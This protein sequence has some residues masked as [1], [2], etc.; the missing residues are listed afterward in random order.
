MFSKYP[1]PFSITIILIIS[2][3]LNQAC[4][5]PASHSYENNHTKTYT[6]KKS[7][8]FALIILH[9]NDIHSHDL[10]F[11][12]N[13][14]LIGGLSKIAY[15][16]SA[17][18]ATHNNVIVVDAGDFFQGTP[19]FQRY[20][21]AVEIEALNEI[22]YDIVELG[23][24][25]FDKGAQYLANQLKAAKFPVLACNL[26]CSALPALEQVV[27]A[28]IIKEI[29]GEKIAFIG[30]IT[31][32]LE[33][34]ALGLEGV[35]VKAPGGDWLQPIKEEVEYYQNQGINKI[36][37]VSH[38]GVELDKDLAAAIPSIDLI[39]GGHSHTT[40]K[41]PIWLQH[42]DGTYTAI[43]QTGCY[44]RALGDIDLKFDQ[45]G[46][47]I[48]PKT[49]YRLISINSNL[50]DDP[51]L[52]AYL[53]EKEKPLLALANNIIGTA[54]GTFWNHFANMP[55]DSAIGNL[56][57]DAMAEATAN[58]A[59][60]ITFQNRGGIRAKLEKS[61]I[62]EEKIQEILP[63]DNKIVCATLSG[64]ALLSLL[65]CSLSGPH[66]GAFF[67][68]HGLKI[69]YDP[70]ASPDKRIISILVQNEAGNWLPLEK[71]AS[72]KIAV[73]DYNFKGGDGYDFSKATDVKYTD[74]KLAD[75]LRAYIIKHKHVRPGFSHR[76]M[77]ISK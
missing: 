24:H 42:P 48:K 8:D 1:S 5:L 75:A 7:K 63:F 69:T 73:N 31:P 54:D 65:K 13:G 59:V 26:D 55:A 43:V 14:N 17:I 77:P 23:N 66:Y 64:E 22:G 47:I 74:E 57:C 72:Y 34:K 46:H 45:L 19:L 6:K 37:I 51:Q 29:N 50:Q 36:I 58:C 40:L 44:G 67:D 33:K 27:K 21:G 52:E 10:P 71:K 68:V 9:T 56:I 38:C 20:G 4:A 18:K 76:I 70:E 2:L 30:V 15:L 35:K 60:Q 25:E 62:S 3:S 41:K 32:D 12:D 28:G 53:Q 16:V 11:K 39:V 61:P 49:Q